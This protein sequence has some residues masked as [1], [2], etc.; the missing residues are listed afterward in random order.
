MSNRAF[1]RQVRTLWARLRATLRQPPRDQAFR[2]EIDEHISLLAERYRRQGMAADAAMLAA[3]R[4]F[5]NTTLLKEDRWTM[6]T[7]PALERGR[8]DLT[9]AARMLRKNPGFAA[10]AIVTLALGIGAN[11]AIFSICNAVLFAPLPYTEPDRIVMLW[12][13][14]RGGR[15]SGVAPAN[16][17]DWRAESQ[18]FTDMAAV[19]GTSF[20]LAGQDEA[21]R[22]PGASV[23]ASFFS[24][25]GVRFALGR[26]FLPEEDR[27]GQHRV[28][29]L[30]HQ[31]WQQRFGGDRDI[32]GRAVMLNDDRYIIV[33][34]LPA[35]FQFA[36]N[37]ADFQASSQADIWVPMA[38]DPL[39][40]QR[41]THPLR[42]IARLKPGVDLA[43]AQSALD[44]TGADLARRYPDDN[45]EKGITAVPM[46]EQVTASV[47]VVLKMLLGAVGLVLLIA[48][49]NVANLLLSRAA[50]RQREFAVRVALGASRGRLAQQLLTESLFL[51]GL[52]GAAGFAIA[53]A[54]IAALSPHLPADLSRASSVA[55]DARMLLFTA[56]VSLATGVVFGLGPLFGTRHVHAAESLKQSNRT[57]SALHSRLRNGLA[58]AQIAIAI[59]L[60]IGAG[61]MAKSFWALLRVAPGFRS[62][63]LVTA[64]LSLSKARYPNNQA[65]AAFERELSERL[66][67]RPGI[68]SVAFAAYV[69]LGG[70]DNGWSFAIEGRPPLPI[71]VYNMAK[72][73]PVSPGYFETIG[74]PLQRGRAFTPADTQDAARVVMIN[75]AMARE[76]WGQED[77]VGRRVRFAGQLRTIIGTVGDVL[78][79]GLDGAT[80]PELY[81]PIEQAPNFQNSPSIVLRTSLDAGTAAGEL[82]AMVAAID[83]ATPVDRIESMDQLIAGSVAQPRFRTL[84]L[85]AFSLLALLMASIGIY[86]VMNYLV[87]QR[88]REFGI[89]LS[90]G[91]TRADVLRLVLGRA[92]AL[93]A[94]GTC[95]GLAGAMLLVRFIAKLLFGT[96]P[97]DPLTFAAV[98]I[99]LAS[100]ALAASYIPARRATRIDPMVALRYE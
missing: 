29:I 83:R 43:R 74:I 69:P 14:P 22:L 77:P 89:R 95:V 21:A 40:L 70:V 26:D 56:V 42:V 16:F 41:G 13:H 94:A 93:I 96:T 75:S 82:R 73:R 67:A 37:A 86:G 92:A 76:H 58:V 88:T 46:A 48:C 51:A 34:V 3:R 12:E 62:E 99:L 23:T 61:L 55:V 11:T 17:V 66:R 81:V 71:G 100:V 65:I 35:G 87:V 63:S 49:A 27:P 39:K 18:S 45:R 31:I 2:D 1:R 15:F 79:E 8:G 64:R 90:V 50:A 98:P 57:A 36:I 84:I 30:S 33:G 44:V 53:L 24:V 38:L 60:L 52:G 5:G 10:A 97:L 28:A 80:K 9:Y 72:Y 47:R 20:I 6:Q 54:A 19:S 59:V 32:A 78:H 68:Q 91:A 85:A 4:Q 25:L 7:M